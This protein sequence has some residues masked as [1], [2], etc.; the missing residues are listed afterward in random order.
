MD[1]TKDVTLR[2]MVEAMSKS[3]D[4]AVFR[5]FQDS[6]PSQDGSIQPGTTMRITMRQIRSEL[7]IK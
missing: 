1:Y 4:D 7:G 3:P 5:W 2:E 6:Y